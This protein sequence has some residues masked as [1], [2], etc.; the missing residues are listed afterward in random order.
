MDLSCDGNK[1]SPPLLDHLCLFE[2]EVFYTFLSR[3]LPWERMLE[4]LF[5]FGTPDAFPVNVL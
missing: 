5:L 4:L 2:R 3:A 1:A